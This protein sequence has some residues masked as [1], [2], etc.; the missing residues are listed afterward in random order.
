M[1]TK[2]YNREKAIEYAKRWANS[3]NPDYYNYEFLGGDCTNFISQC[4]FAGTGIMNY[5]KT[6]GWYY[7]NANDK[8]PSWTGVEFLYNFLVSN[9]SVGPFGNEVTRDIIDIGD[10]AQLSFDG[11]KF[12]HNLIVVNRIGDKIYVAT[13]T[14]DSFNRS[15]DTYSFVKARFIKIDGF[16]IW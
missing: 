3:R 16:R 9:K 7:I 12:G 13:H 4:I 8:S 2:Q 1:Q 5:N 11:Y 6:N 15:L 10:V 14:F